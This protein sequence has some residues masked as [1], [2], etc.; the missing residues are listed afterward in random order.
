MKL[1]QVKI[2]EK[3][4]FFPK[5]EAVDDNRH[6]PCEVVDVKRLVRVRIF[7]QGAEDG[8][9]RSVSAKR[10]QQQSELAV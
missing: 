5:K 8:V 7:M 9:L 1:E 4:T 10:L 2:G 3:Y 6:F